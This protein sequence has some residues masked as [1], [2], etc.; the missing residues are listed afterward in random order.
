MPNARLFPV[1]LVIVLVA[2]A[3]PFE[4]LGAGAEEQPAKPEP[5][6]AGSPRAVVLTFFQSFADGNA[7]ALRDAVLADSDDERKVA[8]GMAQ[9]AGAVA[10]ARKAVVAKFNVRDQDLNIRI[11]PA[12][13]FSG[14]T[15][16]VD[17]DTASLMQDGQTII[18]LKKVNGAW[19]VALGELLKQGGKTTDQTMKE[20]HGSIGRVGQV[21]KDVESGKFTDAGEAAKAISEAVPSRDEAG[22]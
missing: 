11:I 15:E 3:G 8:D 2:V 10:S 12:G 16:K 5:P 14:M 18:V 21:A 6:K 1:M 19:K 22:Q 7:A 13:V 20:L 4:R 9:V 17:D